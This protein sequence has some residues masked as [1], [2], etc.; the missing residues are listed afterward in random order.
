LTYLQLG[1]ISASGDISNLANLTLLTYLNLGG[2][3]VTGD[4][5]CLDTQVL[6]TIFNGSWCSWSETEVGNCLASLVINEAAGDS[7]RDCNVTI[8][9]NN[10]APSADGL[11]DRDI[12]VTD[13][14][15]TVTVT[16]TT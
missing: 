8:D 3:S 1:S 15:W 7:A 12:L 9:G 5:N 11:A 14:G 13:K 10:A 6:M 4:A 2:T 16:V